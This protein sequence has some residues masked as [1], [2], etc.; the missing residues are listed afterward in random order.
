MQGVLISL[1]SPALLPDTDSQAC[2]KGMYH[3]FI[4]VAAVQPDTARSPLLILSLVM[5]ALTAS[6]H[7]VPARL[8]EAALTG[9]PLYYALV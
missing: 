8:G 2:K 4:C 1:L 9:V 5:A 7:T 3:P 6:L